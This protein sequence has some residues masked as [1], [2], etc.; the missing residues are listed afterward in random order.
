MFTATDAASATM[1]FTKENID[2]G[3][4]DS[5]PSRGPGRTPVCSPSPLKRICTSPSRRRSI[6]PPPTTSRT[7][8]RKLYGAVVVHACP[9]PDL[10]VP[11]ASVI[12][13][14][15]PIHTGPAFTADRTR[16]VR[17]TRSLGV[18]PRQS[19]GRGVPGSRP[20]S[21][22]GAIPPLRRGPR[23]PCPANAVESFSSPQAPS[24]SRSLDSLRRRDGE[25]F[26]TWLAR[27]SEAF[28]T[29]CLANSRRDDLIRGV[30]KQ[31][32]AE[33]RLRE[34]SINMK[35]SKS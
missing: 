33:A 13:N 24:P 20:K 4:V 10:V 17:S 8:Q 16:S 27:R 2:D 9:Q 3:A 34:K 35:D 29:T 14:G 5:P 26:D 28:G 31:Q 7:P 19:I 12:A 23:I 30:L 6:S 25:S 21:H 32:E 15:V 11:P 1:D 22:G 18:V